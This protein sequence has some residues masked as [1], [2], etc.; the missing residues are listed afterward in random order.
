LRD[1]EGHIGSC[2][3]LLK[4]GKIVSRLRGSSIRRSAIVLMMPLLTP[5]KTN[6]GAKT[7]ANP[8]TAQADNNR[9]W[10]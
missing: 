10:K 2:R 1:E 3:R 8:S 6:K 5:N 7:A 9:S 4:P